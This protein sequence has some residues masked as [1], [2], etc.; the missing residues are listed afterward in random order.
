MT[1]QCNLNQMN[2]F[3]ESVKYKVHLSRQH[4]I[5]IVKL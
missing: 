3:S 4:F 1:V 2:I 5:S